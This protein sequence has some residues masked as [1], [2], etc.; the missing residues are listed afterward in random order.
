[1][2]AKRALEAS[3]KRLPWQVITIGTDGTIRE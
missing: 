3:G 1:M 2:A